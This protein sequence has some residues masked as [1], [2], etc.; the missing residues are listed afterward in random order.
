MTALIDTK[1][2]PFLKSR[3]SLLDKTN[4][5][6]HIAI[7][8]DGNRRWANLQKKTREQGHTKGADIILDIVKAAR[9]LGVKFVTIFT[10]STENWQRPKEEVAAL[11]ILLNHYLISQRGPMIENGVR[12]EAI[13]D[14]SKF[15][16][17]IQKELEITKDITKNCNA[18]TLV[19]ALN[20]GGRN[21]IARAVQKI[22]EEGHPKVT[23]E[24]ITSHLDTAHFP[25]PDLLIRTSGEHRFS[26]FLL[27]QLSY[28]EFYSTKLYW[29]E[30]TPSDLLE[31]ILDFQQRERRLGSK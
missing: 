4:I 18:I 6:K 15:P 2:T 12:L 26:N 7:I 5:P 13:G 24:L 29:P 16:L 19:L 27:W 30:F 8:P 17:P 10:F 28:T 14:I 3:L 22:L 25:D 21:D 31:A 1:T 11:M 20:Y 23:E 9:D